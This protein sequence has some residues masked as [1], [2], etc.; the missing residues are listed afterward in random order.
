VASWSALYRASL[1]AVRDTVDSVDTVEGPPLAGASCVNSVNSVTREREADAAAE[2]AAI[3]D[4]PPLPLPGSAKRIRLD[5]RH[6][7]LVAGLL[8][9]AKQH[10][11]SAA[12]L[13]T[14]ER[15]QPPNIVP[16]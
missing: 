4:E 15:E 12:K 8:A 10:L 11:P 3:M 7:V 13:R 9:A 5:E 6:R 1:S 14:I 2:R 16:R